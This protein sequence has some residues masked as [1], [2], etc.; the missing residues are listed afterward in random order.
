MKFI[1]K[2]GERQIPVEVERHGSGYSVRVGERTL[3]VDLVSANRYLQSARFDD[4]TQLLI[5][6]HR[7]GVRYEIS[8]GH[9]SVSLELHDPLAMNRKRTEEDSTGSASVTAMMPG[10]V[11]RILVA[12]GQEVKKGDG[13]VILEAMKMENEIRAPRDGHVAKVSVTAG[14]TVERG[15]ELVTLVAF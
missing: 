4:G 9:R 8:F 14:V 13:L 11:V 15:A 7:D 1:A 5:A 2:A 10:R 12:E 3:M 6:H